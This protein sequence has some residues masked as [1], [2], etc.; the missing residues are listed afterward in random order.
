MVSRLGVPGPDA[1]WGRV[2]PQSAP[3]TVCGCRRHQRTEP[4]PAVTRRYGAG[5][6]RAGLRSVVVRAGA[7]AQNQ[8]MWA[9]GE[10]AVRHLAGASAHLEC[11][12]GEVGRHLAGHAA[13]LVAA[14]ARCRG[15]FLVGLASETHCQRCLWLLR[16]PGRRG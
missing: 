8:N 9:S 13:R 3:K 6:T 1:G 5:H 16:A 12:V 15:V 2:A 4:R 14:C 7:T 11:R 10:R